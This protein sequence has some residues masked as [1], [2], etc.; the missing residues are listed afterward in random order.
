MALHDLKIVD[1]TLREGEQF[2]RAHFTKAQKREIALSL[3]AF[4][5]EYIELTN[6][7]ASPCSFDDARMIAGLGLRARVLVHCRCTM[8]DAR[9]AVATGAHGVNVLFGTSQQLREHSHGRSVEQI[10]AAA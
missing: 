4:G 10:I 3:D 8:E 1:S 7:S 2:A 5:V 9:R 6:P